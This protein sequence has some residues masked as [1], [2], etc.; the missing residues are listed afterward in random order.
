MKILRFLIGIV[1]LMGIL[2]ISCN[3]KEIS[4][5]PFVPAK[6]E[7]LS[8]PIPSDSTLEKISELLDEIAELE[9]SGF[10]IQGM[11]LIESGLRE[12]NGDFSGAVFAAYKELSRLYSQGELSKDEIVLTLRRIIESDDLLEKAFALDTA[13]A[14]LAFIYGNWDEA[15]EKLAKIAAE[16]DEPDSFSNWMLL[17]C[18]LE[19][20]ITDRKTVNL[21]KAI[22]SRYSQ[23]PEYWY[24]GARAFSGNIAME[25][26]EYCINLAPS[27]PFA[28]EC[29]N[30]LAVNSGLREEDG[31][32]LK[33]KTE[34]ENL[35]FMAV[36]S[37]EPELLAPLLL[38]MDL[39]ENPFTMF[40]LNALKNLSSNP[41]FNDY[42]NLHASSSKGRLAD[43]LLYISRS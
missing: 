3:G 22:R 29:R 40:T 43:R 19:N 36:S 33:S 25:Y 16:D 27:G 42:F 35:I 2:L 20:N 6:A 7:A 10:F 34:I 37:G 13:N 38:L 8:V 31:S 28:A 15:E 26:A 9:R 5:A 17:S 32:V 1:F 41:L 23:Y 11:G 18:Y 24:R 4:Q 12:R 21:Y 14:I 39:P 30:L